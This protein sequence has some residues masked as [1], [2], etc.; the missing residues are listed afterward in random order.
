MW[1]QY[2]LH[3]IKIIIL[4]GKASVGP[5]ITSKL[6]GNHKIKFWTSD[7][8]FAKTSGKKI[9]ARKMLTFYLKIILKEIPPILC[10]GILIFLAKQH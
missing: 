10:A 9:Q 4:Q 5:S 6:H 7:L 1:S 8:D 2:I 3:D